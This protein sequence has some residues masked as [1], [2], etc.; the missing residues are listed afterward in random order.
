MAKTGEQPLD[1]QQ[2]KAIFTR[3]AEECTAV[4]MKSSQGQDLERKEQPIHLKI[5]LACIS[6]CRTLKA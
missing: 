2:R 1:N 5:K 3:M 6:A 4:Q